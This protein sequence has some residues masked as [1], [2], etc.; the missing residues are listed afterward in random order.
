MKLSLSPSVRLFVC[1]FIMKEFFFDLRSYNGVSRKSNGCLK[2]NKGCFMLVLW[3]GSF[4]GVSRKFK[5]S[6]KGVLRK[7]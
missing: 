7:F 1:P 6:F 2:K 5:E 3:I 4:E